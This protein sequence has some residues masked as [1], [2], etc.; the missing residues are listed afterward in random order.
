MSAREFR[1]KRESHGRETEKGGAGHELGP[2]W[3]SSGTRARAG[4]DEGGIKREIGERGEHP[5]FE[6]IFFLVWSI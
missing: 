6:K 2:K 5:V 1:R 3:A 4:G